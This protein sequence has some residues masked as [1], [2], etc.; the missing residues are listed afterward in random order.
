MHAG[1]LRYHD[2]T[3]LREAREHRKLRNQLSSV[4]SPISTNFLGITSSNLSLSTPSTTTTRFF[5]GFSTNSSEY[6]ISSHSNN[7][8]FGGSRISL[9]GHTLLG[10]SSSSSSNNSLIS[11]PTADRDSIT[12][13]SSCIIISIIIRK[14]N[15]L[16]IAIIAILST[17]KCTYSIQYSIIIHKVPTHII[18]TLMGTGGARFVGRDGDA[19]EAEFGYFGNVSGGACRGMCGGIARV[20]SVVCWLWKCEIGWGW[21][22]W[23]EVEVGKCRAASV[24]GVIFLAAPSSLLLLSM[25]LLGTG[26][27]ITT[28][29]P[30][31]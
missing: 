22:W 18:A 27:K 5:G 20:M 14:R 8:G 21:W 15:E 7:V 11:T 26:G 2:F 19:I 3:L 24:G 1:Q 31:F 4:H 12:T 23:R 9:L 13:R 6:G 10:G 29:I 17:P 25:V 16:A 30:R 28:I